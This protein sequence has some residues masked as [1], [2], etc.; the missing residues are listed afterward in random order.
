MRVGVKRCSGLSDHRKKNLAWLM[1][2]S[3]LAVVSNSIFGVDSGNRIYFRPK[4]KLG[5]VQSIRNFTTFI[6]VKT[7]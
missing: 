5:I 4:S 2:F 1:I 7:H 3:L 6:I